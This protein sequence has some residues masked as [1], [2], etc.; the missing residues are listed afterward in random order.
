M[1]RKAYLVPLKNI[2]F[3]SK[4]SKI[5]FTWTSSGT[6]AEAHER[7]LIG[8]VFRGE[9]LRVEAVWVNKILLVSDDIFEINVDN[10]SFRNCEISVGYLVVFGAFSFM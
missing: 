1:A 5:S 10:P 9:I 3:Y 4:K 7:E 2:I 8:V 6:L